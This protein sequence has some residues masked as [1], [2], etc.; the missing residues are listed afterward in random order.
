MTDA[1]PAGRLLF[2]G[3]VDLTDQGVS[4]AGYRFHAHAEG[5]SIGDPVPVV[6]ELASF[7]R[8]GGV[9]RK[10][11]DTNRTMVL[12]VEVEGDDAVS[13]QRG[14]SAL[15]W[16]T[17]KATTLVWT[18]AELLGP[19][20][21]VFDVLTSSLGNP[22]FVDL[23]FKR[24]KQTFRLELT[25]L[26]FA[27]SDLLV[28]DD[29]DTPA[30]AGVVVESCDSLTGWTT[31]PGA[32][33]S[34]D[35][36]TKVQGT[37]AVKVDAAVDVTLSP[38]RRDATNVSTR[39]GLSIATG[40][41]GYLSVA[42]RL[43]FAATV[44]TGSVIR[45]E[46]QVAGAW[47]EVAS[48]S[49]QTLAFNYVR[50]SWIVAPSLTVTG[51][52]IVTFQ[53]TTSKLTAVQPTVHFDDIELSAIATTDQQVVKGFD[54]QGSARAPGAM[55]IFAPSNSVALGQVLA[56]TVA[57]SE[58]KP[59]F[60]P[61]IRQFVTAGTTTVDAAALLGSYYPITD[62]YGPLEIKVPTSILRAGPYRVVV[63]GHSMTSIT[64]ETQLMIGGVTT[65]AAS[66][67]SVTL[68]VTPNTYTL[69]PVGT[70]YLPTIPVADNADAVVRFRVKASTAGRLAEIF[71][72]PEAADFSIV[73][74]GTGSVSG[75]LASSHL[76]IDSPSPEEPEGSWWRGP[77]E[78]R[79]NARSAWSSLVKPGRH[80]FT[81]GGMK[82]FVCSLN[83]QGPKVHLEYFPCGFLSGVS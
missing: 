56:A 37:G 69:T 13:F 4:P 72:V 65:G 67:E 54:V 80:V 82:V 64:V 55:H 10:D 27:R 18:S 41:G 7:L 32:V 8:D 76:W 75:A 22:T 16:A 31:S 38:Y 58:I 12:L 28:I 39:T 52:R 48:F 77:L 35:T 25:C 66:E 24:H 83:A 2:D 40:T 53:S 79:G 29:A 42:V 63:A 21:A 78:G 49:S 1:N 3:T 61:N 70:M 20:S 73:D 47:K 62:A 43:G 9:V 44:G 5:F 11:R 19:R 59:G 23:D 74:C 68:A 14:V 15:H 30:V 51:L 6:S 17:G 71:V 46:Q 34:L 26:P 33:L 50:W 57:D 45:I 81:P 60:A 36:T